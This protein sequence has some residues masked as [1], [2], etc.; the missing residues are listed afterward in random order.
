MGDNK[1][2]GGAA[3]CRPLGAAPKA[4][5]KAAAAA[6]AAAAATAPAAGA[7]P[8]ATAAAAPR[9]RPR[10]ARSI[11]YSVLFALLK[12]ESPARGAK[13][14]PKRVEPKIGRKSVRIG[15]LIAI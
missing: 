9:P 14:G 4:S 1:I 8:A 7:G 13:N 12:R 11:S 6:A 2:Q 5:P 3:K 10:V 15:P